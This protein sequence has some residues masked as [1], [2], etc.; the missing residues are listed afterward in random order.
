METKC[1][2]HGRCGGCNLKYMPYKDELRFKTNMVSKL[3]DFTKTKVENTIGMKNPCNYRY[4]TINSYRSVGKKTISG[5]YE[6]GSHHI[7]DLDSCDIQNEIANKIYASFKAIIKD[8]KILPYDEDKGLGHIRHVLIRV[9]YY[10]HE[11]LVCIVTGSVMLPGRNNLVKRLI[12][13]NKEI[14]TIVQNVNSRKTSVVLGEKTDIIYGPGYINDSLCGF[15][16]SIS[17]KSFYQVNP[18]Q[19]ETLYNTAI[20]LAEINKE[21]RVLD[22]YSGIGTITLAASRY[23]KEVL[24]VEIVKDAYY[25][26]MKNARE[27][28]VKN[29]KF[30]LDDA[31]K[32]MKKCAQDD[33]H[34]DVVFMDPPRKGSDVIFLEA[35]MKLLPKKIIYI[36]CNPETQAR[37][38]KFILS[39]NK[40][41]LKRIQPVDMFPRTAHVESVCLLELKK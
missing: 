31:S 2:L 21:D 25:D 24:A 40:Y 6:E 27:N 13:E 18:L 10:S 14:K 28:K 5:I 7:I 15:K 23:A 26:S 34:F 4:K 29:V 19:T 30:Y 32:F 9:G 41:V 11:A 33:E 3:F 39:K 12:E 37:D 8:M 38:I 22:T 35:L 36:S 1:P 17:P 16:F 20:T